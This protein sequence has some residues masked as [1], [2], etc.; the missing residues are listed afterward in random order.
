MEHGG[1]G[2]GV[3]EGGVFAERADADACDG[4]SDDYS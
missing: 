4:A 1:F 3:T 2:G